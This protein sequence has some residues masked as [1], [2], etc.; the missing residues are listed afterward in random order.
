[1]ALGFVVRVIPVPAVLVLG[2]WVV[3]QVVNSVFTFARG[4]TAGVAFMAHVGGFLVGLVL[5]G[6]FR[7]PERRRWY[8]RSL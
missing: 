3:L 4:Q 1:V 7:R 2:F 5:I 8:R 6:L